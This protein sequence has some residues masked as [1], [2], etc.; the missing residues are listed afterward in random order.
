MFRLGSDEGDAALLDDLGEFG[1]LGKEAIAR[2]DRLR[3]GNL[4]GG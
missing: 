1:V 2:M 3:A 4:C